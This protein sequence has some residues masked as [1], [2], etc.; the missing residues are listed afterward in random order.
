M[1]TNSE[2]LADGEDYFISLTKLTGKKIVDVVGN[3][4]VSESGAVPVFQMFRIVFDD[5]TSAYCEGEHDFSYL[6]K[7]NGEFVDQEQMQALADEN[8]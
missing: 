3:V 8:S 1:K 2:L 7:G 4:T 5:G 6:T